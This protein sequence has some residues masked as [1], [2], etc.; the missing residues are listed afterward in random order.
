MLI[1]LRQ[2]FRTWLFRPKIESGTVTLNQ[3]R[4]FILPTLRGLGFAF[5]LLLMLVGDINYNLSLGYVLTFL[6]VTIAV[7]T[8]LHAFR[9]MVQLEVRAGHTAAVFAGETAQFVFHFHNHGRLPRYQLTLHDGLGHSITFDIP[10]QQSVAVKLPVPA[11]QRGWLDAG[12]LTLFTEFPLGL[13]HAW[14]YVQFDT[15]CLVY[16]KP[17]APQP[18]PASPAQEGSGALS[19]AGDEDFAGL[20]G[21]V[22][23][24][25]LP[26]IA[27][28]ALAREQGLQV[29]QFSALAGRQLWLD[30]ALLPQLD[31]ERRLQV[32]TRWVLDADAQELQYG[33]RLPKVELPP[34]H[35]TT[36]R[37]ECLRALAL[38][39]RRDTA[40]RVLSN[41]NKGTTRRSPTAPLTYGLLTCILLVSAPHAEHLPLWLSALAATLLGWRAYLAYSGNPLPQRWLLFT[42]TL[43]SVGGILISF[44]TLFGR[45]AGVALLILLAALKL[46]ELR[47]VRDATVV[48]YLACFIILSNFFY[49]QSIATALFML[50][51]L[52]VIM[53]T[54]VHLQTSTLPLKP[55]LRIASVLLL[56]A[57]PLTLIL[58]VLFPRVQGPLWGLPQDA[59]ATSGLDDTMSPGSLSKLSL[60]EAVAFRVAFTGQ[61]PLH[62]QMYWRGPVLWDFDGRTWTPGKTLRFKPPQLDSLGN[63]I[64]YT[65]TLEPHNKTWLFA[66]EM[67]TQLSIP[68]VLTHDFQLLRRAPV[69]ARLRYPMHS[70]LSYRANAEEEPQQLQRALALPPGL[71]PRARQ[72][73]AGWRASLGNDD[74]VIRAA[75]T[76]YNRENFSYT[77]EP[78]PLPSSNTVDDFLFETRQGFC[79]HYASSF[80]FLMRAAGIPARV[81]TGYQGAEYND[82]GNYYIVRQSAAHAWAE[83]WLRER[84]WVR[85]DPTTAIA[86]ER[87]QSGLAAAMPDSAALPFFARTQSP[88]LRKLRF[89]LDALANQWNQ[90][91]L[92]YDTER[93][94][95]FLT[96][97]GMESVTWQKMALTMLAG[98]A[99]L[100]GLFTLLMLRRLA[101]RHADQVQRLYLKFCRKLGKAGIARAAHEGPQDFAARAAQIKPQRASAIEDITARYVALRYNSSPPALV[102]RGTDGSDTTEALRALRRAVASFKL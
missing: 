16:P 41:I 81:V 93:Q 35:G 2:K 19:V 8:M 33:L 64:D 87:V 24:D 75:I 97:L 15:R 72:L 27:W 84:G 102:G 89:N 77:L 32:L 74:A 51:T 57:I 85:I 60:S 1:A 5:L 94:F 90:W 34:G 71:S 14:S 55:R 59:Y 4:I 58:F 25:A 101:V 86:P 37:A 49:S 83:V 67:P 100:V 95:G 40:R 53:T 70:Q 23:G 73:A 52:L 10:A 28:K 54:W 43:G 22:A 65:V 66:L 38:H 82:L 98:V 13:F 76:H 47:A 42:I 45:D 78:P 99:L 20:R 31:S 69:T 30:W 29:K 26:R 80:V 18:L 48:I 3:R 96:R 63:A 61:P 92:G 21:Y 62:E 9:N 7:V 6:L 17:S 68:A 11:A 91:V 36:H 46:L 12:R 88:W 56:Q 44:H 39:D 79:E 50:V